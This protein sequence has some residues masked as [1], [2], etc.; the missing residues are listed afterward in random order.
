MSQAERRARID[1]T[2]CVS[3]SRPC[4]ILSLSRSS[5]SYRPQGTEEAE[6]ALMRRID[7]SH[8]RLPFYGTR[9]VRDALLDEQGL[10]VNRKRVQRL[11]RRMGGRTAYPGSQKTSPPNRAH[12]LC[13]YLLRDREINR[14]NQVGCADI[15]Y[16]PLVRGWAYLV[17]IRDWHSGKVRSGS[18]FNVADADFCTEALHKALHR[19]GAPQIFNTDQGSRL[20]SQPFT[21]ELK[22]HRG[23]ISMEGKGR[24]MD[25]VFIE[26]LWRSVQYEAVY[27]HAYDSI[28]QAR[29]H[30]KRDCEF[31]NTKRKHQTLEATPDPV[32]YTHLP[33]LKKTG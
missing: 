9:R 11:M 28:A 5:V 3:V 2:H 16:L 8:L 21:D 15:T 29:D 27:L 33:S 22:Q 32:Y 25:N 13:P 26:R 1:S 17:A 30:L 20:T 23:R 19:Y 10:T 4:R 31:Y 14:S 6:L 18:L 7:E 12:R 24:W